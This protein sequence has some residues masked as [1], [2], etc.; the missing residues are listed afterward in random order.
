M[1]RQVVYPLST[2]DAHIDAYI[3]WVANTA[4]YRA[5]SAVTFWAYTPA[6]GIIVT[7]ALHDTSGAE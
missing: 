4:S 7:A 1:G 3:R 2:T 6:T 5:G